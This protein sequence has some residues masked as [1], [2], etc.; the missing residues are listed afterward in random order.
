[1]IVIFTEEPSMEAL[2]RDLINRC[3]PAH[4]EFAD[5]MILSYSGKSD[6]ERQF[7]K[8]MKGWSWGDPRFLI[9]RDNDGGDCRALKKHLCSL[10]AASGKPYKVRIVCQELEGWFIG[11]SLAV[12]AAYPRCK[13]SNDTAKYRDPDRLTNA[14]DELARL[15][16]DRTKQTRASLIAPHLDPARNH[17][18]SFRLFFE[19]LHRL[20]A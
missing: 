3:F 6:L 13:F 12:N 5:W 16:G 20:L 11:D 18:R 9:L 14:S 19:T 8:R 17:S 7:P 1:M 2:V 15:T 4:G 10:A